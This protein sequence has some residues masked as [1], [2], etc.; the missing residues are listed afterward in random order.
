MRNQNKQI[1]K[2][3]FFAFLTS[4]ISGIAIFYSK[5]SLI[6]I[7]PL[8]LTSSRNFYVG[9]LF[10]SIFLFSRKKKEFKKLQT[11]EIVKLVL[12]GLIGGAL[13][14]Y[15]F[16]TGLQF[17]SPLTANLIHK[18]LFIWVSILGAVFLYERLNLLYFLSYSLLIIAFFFFKPLQL[19]LG[20]GELMILSATLL[21]SIEN[22][23][24]KKVLKYVSS[25]IVGLFRMGIGSI[26]LIFISLFSGRMDQF[27][28]L[29]LSS[30]LVIITGGSI[31]FGYVFF[32]YK[33]LKYAPASLVAMILSFSI[34]VG[35]I[36]KSLFI[37]IKIPASSLY[38]SIL[39]G[40]SMAL[41]LLYQ[42]ISQRIKIDFYSKE[43]SS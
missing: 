41:I 25:E 5:L 6:K 14:F 28:S 2:G 34:V 38:S 27:L 40:L 21:W 19:T 37:G 30:I 9:L 36:L 8:I 10:L 17:T 31:L 7:K 22:I 4:I 15:L 29:D 24:A 20:K 23:I 11:K 32:W 35:N 16:F 42:V 12:I 33:A 13:P 26:I 3:V 1:K 43:R 39:I 18:T